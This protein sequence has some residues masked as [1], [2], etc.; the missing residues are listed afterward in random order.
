MVSQAPE[1]AG[2]VFAFD[3]KGYPVSIS[4]DTLVLSVVTPA[5]TVTPT[6]SS[7]HTSAETVTCTPGTW[8]KSSSNAYQ[9]QS[10]GDG[11]TTWT[12]IDGETASTY[13]IDVALVGDKLRC[14]V[15]GVNVLATSV[16]VPTAASAT[17]VAAP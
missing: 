8:S 13:V 5:N 3:A 6:L 17:I 12:N 15:Y 7:Q 10:S 1:L 11:G 16:A 4:T 2:Q 14:L 9:W